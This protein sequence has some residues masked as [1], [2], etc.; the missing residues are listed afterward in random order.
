M[1]FINLIWRI[2][3]RGVADKLQFVYRKVKITAKNSAFEKNHPDFKLPPADLVFDANHN[4][5]W[6]VYRSSGREL[7]ERLATIIRGLVPPPK[8]AI[9]EWGCGPGRILR[10]LAD[11]LPEYTQL[12]LFGADYNKQSVDWCS[13]NISGI[14][15]AENDLLP[16]IALKDET[17][18]LVYAISVFTHMSET[19]TYKWLDEV[20]RLLRHD[21]YFV[22]T[23]HGENFLH[24]LTPDQV[25]EFVAGNLVVRKGDS[26]GKKL[27][28]SFHP[29]RWVESALA[30]SGFRCLSF[31]SAS[32][33]AFHQD[34]WI[35][36]KFH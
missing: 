28:S 35:V 33:S 23:T 6:D 29:T 17:L 12:Q 3:L 36:Q 19:A 16:P 13:R 11:C 14:A 8:A 7:A 25:Q 15:F 2:R 26:E 18:D 31:P 20:S 9:L 10:H 34:L 4:V 22:F 30:Q 32:T 21:G 24:L 27:F 1:K 5:D